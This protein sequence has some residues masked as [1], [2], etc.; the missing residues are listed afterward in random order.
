MNTLPLYIYIII[1][2]AGFFAGIFNIIGGGGSSISLPILIF[3]GLPPH[4]ANGTNRIAIFLQ[5]LFATQ[6]FRSQKLLRMKDALIIAIPASIGSVLGA[7]ISLQIPED[8][9]KKIIGIFLIIIGTTLLIKKNAITKEQSR[10]SYITPKVL[11]LF[12]FVGIY[13]G[14]LQAGVGYFILSGLILV[15]GYNYKLAN[16]IKLT[17]AVVYTFFAIIIFQLS[18][19]IDWI[20]AFVL[21]AGNISGSALSI[22]LSIKLGHTKAIVYILIGLIYSFSIYLIFFK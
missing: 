16:P 13:G 4:I 6:R 9:F 1:F 14:F 22:P 18:G 20:I 19:K 3:A 5:G 12:F 11:I 7:F 17:I 15:A 2:T 8:L 10:D 21:S